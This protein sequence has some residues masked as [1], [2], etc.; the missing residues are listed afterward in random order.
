MLVEL[1]EFSPRADYYQDL[2]ENESQTKSVLIE[3]FL[4]ILGYEVSDPHYVISEYTC[5]V[6]TKKG[7]KV[8]YALLH[9]RNVALL[10]EAK[11]VK[12]KLSDKEI[13]QLFRYFGVSSARIG[14]LTNGL[15]YWFFTDTVKPNVMDTT[16]FFTFN[17][18]NLN[19]G[20]ADILS[21]IHRDRIDLD[22]LK[23]YPLICSTYT[24]LENYFL[25]Q[26]TT[27]TPE[28]K[29][30]ILSEAG[31]SDVELG[32]LDAILRN[33]I[34]SASEVKFSVEI[35]EELGSDVILKHIK[36]P[37]SNMLATYY[38]ENIATES[39]SSDEDNTITEEDTGTEDKSLSHKSNR[40]VGK[41]SL[42]DLHK[43][44]SKFTKPV[45][46]EFSDGTFIVAR[47]W[48]SVMVSLV[49]YAFAKGYKDNLKITIDKGY[50]HGWLSYTP[51]NK[52]KGKW[53]HLS[54]CDLYINTNYSS[55]Q[56]ISKAVSFCGN[57]GIEPDSI[58]IELI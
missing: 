18:L 52:G 34:L 8:D 15:D 4:R 6:G 19:K 48:S 2:I 49:D 1:E 53:K 30:F 37:I 44:D 10:I 31:V 12:T 36:S 32:N 51:E 43:S 35:D 23:D 17:V 47:S 33:S 7:E 45:N 46:L 50:M 28:F 3:P 41:H 21:F 38:D 39:D 42:G 29:S 14:I 26:L 54:D 27:L 11:D 25:N 58:N 55:G 40:L 57:I 5:D 9:N 16:P 24:K 22:K 13:N 56:I 20:V